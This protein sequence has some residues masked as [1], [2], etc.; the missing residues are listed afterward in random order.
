VR[1]DG[2]VR[3]LLDC[4][5]R[6]VTEFLDRR[7]V[8]HCTDRSN[9]DPR[10]TRNRIRSELLP[11]LERRFNPAVRSA[12]ARTAELLAEDEA[13]LDAAARRAA[14]RVSAGDGLE[15]AALRRLSTAIGRRVLRLWLAERRGDLRRIAV[16]HVD[17]LLALA[18]D[19][20][21]GAELSLPGGTVV[22]SGGVLRWTA[23]ERRFA[24][25]FDRPLLAGSTIVLDGWR[26][27]CRVTP[28]G[29]AGT[30]SAWRGQ[31]DFRELDGSTIRVRSPRPGDRM[32]PLG[33]GGSR[34]L[35]DVFVDAKVARE[36]RRS[37][38]V[39]TNG[40]EIV[41]LPGL[42]RSERAL[43]SSGSGRV[44]VIEAERV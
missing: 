16:V 26:L 4:S 36:D 34:K 43:V 31:F 12:L 14:R 22:R 6:E 15:A 3:P 41:W 8:R 20:P 13:V 19:G 39:V 21:K 32:R 23:G 29:R 9:L 7:R 27:Q 18:L 42:V 1:P 37:W 28:R 24:K 30:P 17:R 33:L 40:G 2:V 11:L 35:Q 5:R 10:F 38:P 44:L 25:E